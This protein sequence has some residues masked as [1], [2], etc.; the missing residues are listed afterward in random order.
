VL[1]MSHPEVPELVASYSALAEYQRCPRA[2]QYRYVYTLP[3]RP[4]PEQ[5][6][7]IIVHETLRRLLT[8][9]G[10]G[11][12]ELEEAVAVYDSIFDERPFIDAVN[13]DLWRDRGRDFIV[14]LHRRGRLDPAVLHVP[15]EQSFNL[16]L[17]GFRVRGRMDRID[18]T[19]DGYR[20][21]DYK[22]GEPKQEWELERDLQLGL[23][24]VAAEQVLGLK[25]VELAICYIEDATEIPVLKTTSQLEVDL[26]A[27]HDA[28]AGI[29]A[30]DFHPT[31]GT[32]KC[33]NCDFRLV[34]DAAL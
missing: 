31:P 30:E 33:K 21:I 28:A 3:V 22:T 34:C 26:E 20:V 25:P 2:Y 17:E 9:P 27:A 7:G 23:Y 5:Q 29:M 10:P 11:Q 6:F 16:R 4:S 13:V 12:P 19:R 1:P 8:L 15:P 18:R 14:A 24:A 32:W